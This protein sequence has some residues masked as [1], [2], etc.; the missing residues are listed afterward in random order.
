MNPT[1]TP[2]AR[3]PGQ[4]SRASHH[5]GSLPAQSVILVFQEWWLFLHKLPGLSRLKRCG[6]QRSPW[7]VQFPVTE[8]MPKV[9]NEDNSVTHMF[10]LHQI[11]FCIILAL[12]I[13]SKVH[14]QRS[15]PYKARRVFHEQE[16]SLKSD[17]WG[18][19]NLRPASP[20]VFLC[21]ISNCAS[22]QRSHFSIYFLSHRIAQFL[23]LNTFFWCYCQHN[24]Q[25]LYFSWSVTG[26]AVWWEQEQ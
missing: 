17:T 2:A 24:Q 9:D 12:L 3:T 11:E 19:V 20:L 5:W 25:D 13:N 6:F 8:S 18:S 16:T 22:C 26:L 15:N 23:A 10:T 1:N 7:S 14:H 21:I 4:L